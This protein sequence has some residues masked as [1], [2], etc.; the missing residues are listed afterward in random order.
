MRPAGR[1]SIE[2]TYAIATNN[3]TWSWLLAAIHNIS[4]DSADF[5]SSSQ[6]HIELYKTLMF[7]IIGQQ[8]TSLTYAPLSLS[9]RNTW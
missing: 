2:L 6:E 4:A 3:D 9:A 1:P 7:L 5:A 8:N